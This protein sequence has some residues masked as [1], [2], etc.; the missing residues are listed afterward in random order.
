MLPT[1]A[2]PKNP[3]HLPQNAVRHRYNVFESI[4]LFEPTVNQLLAQ[5]DVRV[6]R[7][8]ANLLGSN[9]G[10]LLT[11]KHLWDSY[12]TDSLSSFYSC[13]EDI[14]IALSVLNTTSSILSESFWERDGMQYILHFVKNCSASVVLACVK[15]LEFAAPKFEEEGFSFP[16]YGI[17]YRDVSAALVYCIDNLNKFENFDKINALE[18]LLFVA[19]SNFCEGM[20]ELTKNDDGQAELT[21]DQRACIDSLYQAVNRYDGSSIAVLDVFLQCESL[22]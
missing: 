5:N 2:R 17:I 1:A 20:R 21:S 13:E 10:I 8:L 4:E 11:S 12:A 14:E 6:R 9:V 3:G 16:Q 7:E 18:R 19:I 22:L 15:V